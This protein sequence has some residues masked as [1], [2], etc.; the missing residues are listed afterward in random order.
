MTISVKREGFFYQNGGFVP[1]AS[2]PAGVDAGEGARPDV[3][4]VDVSSG[5]WIVMASD[6]VTGGEEDWIAETL[7]QWEGD[8]PRLLAQQLLEGCLRRETG[9]DDKTVVA[10]KLTWR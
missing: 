1:A 5:D 2:H 7:A 9:Q 8:S 4:P 10:V 6:G 3:L